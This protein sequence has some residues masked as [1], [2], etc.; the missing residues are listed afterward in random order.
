MPWGVIRECG[1]G[2]PF[3]QVL[4]VL[5]V[6]PKILGKCSTSFQYSHAIPGERLWIDLSSLFSTICMCFEHFTNKIS[7]L[8]S[9]HCAKGSIFYYMWNKDHSHCLSILLA[10]RGCYHILAQIIMK[11]Y[12]VPVTWG[13]RGK[14]AYN[15]QI[16]IVKRMVSR[17][18][19]FHRRFPFRFWRLIRLANF[20]LFHILFYVPPHVRPRV[21]KF[22]SSEHFV[23]ASVPS[24]WRIMEFIQNLLF[25]LLIKLCTVVSFG[26]N[27]A[28]ST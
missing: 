2:H 23:H 15:A 7:T 16:T 19:C 3:V 27:A 22:N 25:G 28:Y 10:N 14:W 9:L 17:R 21:K 11:V 5:H 1:K 18:R 26:D 24:H 20:T 6:M 8:V 12:N 13:R 4:L